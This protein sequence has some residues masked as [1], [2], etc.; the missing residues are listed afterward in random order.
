MNGW[1]RTSG[2]VSAP[3]T[4]AS[5][6][7]MNMAMRAAWSIEMPWSAAASGSWAQARNAS[8]NLERR[9]NAQSP[10]N[11]STAATIT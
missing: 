8:P 3:A 2:A 4:P 7:P 6:A 5:A 10:P 9:R 1:M 11:S